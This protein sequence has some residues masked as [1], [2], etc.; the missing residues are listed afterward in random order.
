MPTSPTAADQSTAPDV[1]DDYFAVTV[2][3]KMSAGQRAKYADE[4]GIPVDQ[5][6]EHVRQQMPERLRYTLPECSPIRNFMTYG[7]TDAE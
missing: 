6:R 1:A 4:Y 2:T 5:V 3:F 7:L